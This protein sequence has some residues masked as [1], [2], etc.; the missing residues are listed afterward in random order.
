MTA[1]SS[2]R[3]A[4]TTRIID[5]TSGA[6]THLYKLIRAMGAARG[7]LNG[8]F[9]ALLADLPFGEDVACHL[10]ALSVDPRFQTRRPSP[11][12]IEAILAAFKAVGAP[13]EQPIIA[14]VPAEAAPDAPPG[15]RSTI[16]SYAVLR[17]LD[18]SEPWAC[19]PIS[20]RR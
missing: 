3:Y 16:A 5:H 11:E 1:D 14:A 18:S 4:L 7:L 19:R 8:S 15:E 10:L 9:G 6:G 13:G 12:A 2:A 20:T 17:W